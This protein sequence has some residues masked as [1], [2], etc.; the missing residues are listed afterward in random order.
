MNI[1]KKTV[2]LTAVI[3]MG[4]VFLAAP[5]SA[6]FADNTASDASGMGQGRADVKGNA[7]AEG[8]ASFS[9]SFTGKGKTE[10]D[11]NSQGTASTNLGGTQR[12]VYSPPY[13]SFPA[14]AK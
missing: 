9:M 2:G 4:F 13:Y 1:I 3:A 10:G 12:D 7:Q 5:A 8:E 11:L 6:F 14:E